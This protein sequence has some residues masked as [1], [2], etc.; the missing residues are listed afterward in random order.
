MPVQVALATGNRTIVLTP[1]RKRNRYEMY[2]NAW[3]LLGHR[4]WGTG[5]SEVVVEGQVFQVE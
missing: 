3:H 4:A 2:R 1:S 5:G